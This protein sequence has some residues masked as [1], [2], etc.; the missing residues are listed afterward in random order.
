MTLKACYIAKLKK[1]PQTR[2][3]VDMSRDL[4]AGKEVLSSARELN[5]EYLVTRYVDA[6]N[7]IPAEMYDEK[8]AT[9]HLKCAEVVLRWIQGLLKL[10]KK[11]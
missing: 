9:M 7:D 10:E 6:A 2:N 5:P 11:S 1:L 3:L 4:G 8:S